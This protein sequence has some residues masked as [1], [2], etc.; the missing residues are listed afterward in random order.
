MS[1]PGNISAEQLGGLEFFSQLCCS[2]TGLSGKPLPL[3]WPL[4]SSC[5]K[6]MG[7]IRTFSSPCQFWCPSMWAAPCQLSQC[8]LADARLP[9]TRTGTR[10]EWKVPFPGRM[11]S[12]CFGLMV[13]TT[14]PSPVSHRPRTLLSERNPG[15][16]TVSY[17]LC[18]FS[19]GGCRPMN[20]DRSAWRRQVLAGSAVWTV[21]A[22]PGQQ[23]ALRE[24][25]DV[26][27]AAR[28]SL[29]RS[30]QATPP[31]N[32]TDLHPAPGQPLGCFIFVIL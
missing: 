16:R 5:V 22:N 3:P 19:V 18:V 32:Q 6:Q 25:P 4:P 2:L 13:F 27:R 31:L 15:L 24:Q 8:F 1:F 30:S 21:A 23:R 14:P 9:D 28:P 10:P 7:F 20:E 17:Q 26:P 12:P 11:L 29:Q